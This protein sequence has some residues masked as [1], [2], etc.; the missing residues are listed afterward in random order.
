MST[1]SQPPRKETTGSGNSSS[2]PSTSAPSP[3]L[4]KYPYKGASD[5]ELER[6]RQEY[7]KR[8]NEIAEERYRRQSKATREVVIKALQDESLE[9]M[10]EQTY[11]D[12][13]IVKVTLKITK[14]WLEE[15][16]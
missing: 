11:A 5:A 13:D 14:E 3:G 7:Q 8:I 2:T 1:S 15:N 6:I 16:G 12:P 9:F 10:T 4:L